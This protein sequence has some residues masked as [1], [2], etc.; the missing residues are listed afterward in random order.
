MNFAGVVALFLQSWEA[1]VFLK[2]VIS[3]LI[4][5]FTLSVFF[6]LRGGWRWH[7]LSRDASKIKKAAVGGIDELDQ[8]FS[9][10]KAL[11]HLWKEYRDTLHQVVE[12]D[13]ETHTRQPAVFRATIPASVIFT[14]EA[15]V[16]S[17]NSVEF[18]KH[19]PGLFTGIGIIGTFSGLVQGLSLFKISD[20]ASTVRMS[21]QDLMHGVSSAFTVSAMAIVLAMSVTFFE[22]LLIS[23]LY[24]RVEE[25]VVIL[26]KTFQSGVGEEYLSR[27]VA[28]SESSAAQTGTLKDALVTDLKHILTELTD[29]QMQAT[30]DLGQ[31]FAHSL[32]EGMKAPLERIANSFQATSQSNSDHVG[33][34]INEVLTGFSAKIESLFGGQISGI[35]EMQQKTILALEAAVSKFNVMSENLEAAGLRTS[36]SMGEKLESAI[37]AMELRQNS[38]NDQMANFVEQLRAMVKDSQSE[39]SQEFQKRLAEIGGAVGAQIEALKSQGEQ[40]LASH[41]AREEQLGSLNEALVSEVRA[42]TAET[43]A[44]VEAMRDVTDTTVAKM[45]S[46]AD[47][48]YHAST[49]FKDAGGRVTEALNKSAD[50][51]NKL[52]TASDALSLMVM[53]FKEVVT[54]YAA[55]RDSISI[56]IEELKKITENAK[57]EASIT[58][59]VLSRINDA[60]NRLADVQEKSSSYIDG[61]PPIVTRAHAEF[62]DGMKTIVQ[63]GY[64]GVVEDLS[65]AT[66]LL[67][68]AIQDLRVLVEDLHDTLEKQPA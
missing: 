11:S 2:A 12:V 16:D 68:G 8:A 10:Q 17:P 45:N 21:L 1:S 43:R 34:M 47:I 7:Q 59:D 49:E 32:N 38:M 3:V 52:T 55:T 41:A 20:D 28:A 24:K 58:A 35:N 57:S 37:A 31:Q 25:I 36:E 5:L 18:F 54:N 53:T 33:S 4:F 50:V 42:I 29:R 6:L 51:S 15:I 40:A 66:G 19:F 48:M 39:T 64:S 14:P 9:G 30:R 27:L 22:K 26:D 62:I 61:L 60:A 13:A 44:T 56:M 65:K 46:G 63:N 23:R 67:G